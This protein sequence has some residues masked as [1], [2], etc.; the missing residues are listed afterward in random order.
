MSV[1][2]PSLLFTQYTDLLCDQTLEEMFAALFGTA[3]EFSCFCAASVAF[4][5]RLHLFLHPIYF[6]PG[7][8]LGVPSHLWALD[9][10]AGTGAA[11]GPQ[12]MLP[13][14]GEC[15]SL[16]SRHLPQRGG[17][18]ATRGGPTGGA[19][20]GE[21]KVAKCC[22]TTCLV[23]TIFCSMTATTSLITFLP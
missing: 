10:Q 4:G 11:S 14:W 19:H 3:R 1:T 13:S 8:Q 21:D 23:L 17:E 5:L 7:I 22:L 9:W 6:L 18:A 12:L 16:P 20:N 15:I 2:T